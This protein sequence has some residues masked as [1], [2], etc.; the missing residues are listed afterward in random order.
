MIATALNALT[1]YGI[2][3]P[4]NSSDVWATLLAHAPET[5][6]RVYALGAANASDTVCSVAS[7]HTLDTSLGLLTEGDALSAGPIYLR[8]LAFLH[9]GRMEALKRII[10][11]VP[12][13]HEDCTPDT[14][15]EMVLSWKEAI[16]LVLLEPQPQ[17]TPVSLLITTF[18]PLAA[19]SECLRCKE[20]VGA[21]VKAMCQEWASVS[22]TI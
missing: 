18:G 12:D 6:L 17:S 14:R 8:R 19:Q 15:R 20:N 10:A 13:Q 3:P 4:D 21:R 1:K 16:A 5:P 22:R 7:S 11:T 9:A 2:P